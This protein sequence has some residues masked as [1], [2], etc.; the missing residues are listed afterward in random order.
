M[1]YT[2]GGYY[3]HARPLLEWKWTKRLEDLW[4]GTI[5]DRSQLVGE[6]AL[7]PVLGGRS[8]PPPNYTKADTRGFI[9]LEEPRL[10][11]APASVCLAELGFF[12]YIFIYFCSK[13]FIFIIVGLVMLLPCREKEMCSSQ[14]SCLLPLPF[15]LVLINNCSVAWGL[16][17]IKRL[18]KNPP[19]I[20]RTDIFLF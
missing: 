4:S 8:R 16:S 14:H 13:K 20:S 15:L 17:L 12:G 2:D 6:E 19:G 9:I 10:I 7:L 3:T 1:F 11:Y 5:P 18:K